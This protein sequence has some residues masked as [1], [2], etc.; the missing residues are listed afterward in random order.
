M[1]NPA[2]NRGV[3]VMEVPG[4]SRTCIALEESRADHF[5]ERDLWYLLQPQLA[6]V[7]A[8]RCR[9]DALAYNCQIVIGENVGELYSRWKEAMKKAHMEKMRKLKIRHPQEMIPSTRLAV[10]WNKD[11]NESWG[12]RSP[13]GRVKLQRDLASSNSDPLGSRAWLLKHAGTQVFWPYPE[14]QLQWLL[15]SLENL[16]EATLYIVQFLDKYWKE[17]NLTSELQEWEVIEARD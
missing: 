8:V 2:H 11:E 3:A 9:H 15:Q 5:G 13:I 10:I 7:S 12:E 6:S 17:F 1:Q 14:V 4:E 16:D